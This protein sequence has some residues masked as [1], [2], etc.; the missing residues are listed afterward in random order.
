MGTYTAFIGASCQALENKF[1]N[2]TER[3]SK[4]AAVIAVSLGGV[5]LFNGILGL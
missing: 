3:L 5:L 1:I 2:I 4:V